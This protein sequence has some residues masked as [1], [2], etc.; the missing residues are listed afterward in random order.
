M[1]RQRVSG[2]E[3][4]LGRGSDEFLRKALARSL[5]VR[6]EAIVDLAVVR[7][8]LDA[9]KGRREPVWTFVLDVGLAT[10]PRRIPKELRLGPVPERRPRV[11]PAARPFKGMSAVVV[12]TGPAGLFAALALAEGGASLTVLEQGPCLE[13][14]VVAVRDLWRSGTLSPDANVQFGEGGAGTFS[15]GKLTTRIKDPLAREVLELFVEA[16]AP[17]TILETAHPHLGTDGVRAVVRRLRERVEGLG[18]RFTFKEAL[19]EIRRSTRGW[20][21]ETASGQ[22]LEAPLAFLAAGHSARPLFRSLLAL[23]VPFRPKGFAVGVRVEHPQEWVDARQYGAAAG[24]PDLPAAEYFLTYKDRPTGRGVYSFCMCPGGVIVNSASEPERLVTNGMSMS[25]RASGRANAGIVVTVAPEDFGGEP[26]GGI[27]FQEGLERKGYEWG[28]G[29]YFAPAQSLQGFLEGRP[30]ETQP[31][32]TFRPGT[33]P[34]NLRGFFPPWVEEPL[35]RAF[36]H[37]DEKMPG[38]IERG[39]LLAPETRTSGPL[40]LCRAG[41]GSAEGFPGLYLAGEGAGWS[42]GIVSSAV[43]ALRCV[44]ALA[45]SIS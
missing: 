16:G 37:F 14:R 8:S 6:I 34:V 10:R 19:V 39:V 27:A 18:A 15:D 20:L 40:Q 25:H 36:R 1:I 42:G 43:D 35:L 41:D 13:E 5:Q 28:G 9:R 26:E 44:E 3:A 45:R 21:I 33:R 22:V 12:G 17:E 31:R 30:D 29:G 38:F 7:R 4:P 2:I 11:A 23:G 32:T 24:H